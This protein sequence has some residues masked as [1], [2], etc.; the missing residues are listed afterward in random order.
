MSSASP[1]SNGAVG[2]LGVPLGYGASM[3]G[4]D[5]GPAALRVARL[6][7]RIS[8]LGYSVRDQGDMRLD[9][10]ENVPDEHD[11][12]KYLT[13]ISNTCEQLAAQVEGILNTGQL[14]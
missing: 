12:L 2:I 8:A 9:R 10:P 4:V 1:N 11:K 6:K 13:E 3:A 5:M 14:P 7:Q